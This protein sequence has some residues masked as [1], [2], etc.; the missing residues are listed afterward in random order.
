MRILVLDV[1]ATESGALSILQQF[2]REVIENSNQQDKW[3]FVVSTPELSESNNVK[4]L[5]YPWIKKSWFHRLYFDN[6]I[7][8]KIIK[9]LRI[10]YVFSL[11][12][13]IVKRVKVPQILYLHQPLPFVTKRYGLLENPKFWIY[14]NII[15]KEIIRSVKD[16]DS[17]IVQTEWV[18]T[19]LKKYLD[20][21]E[22]IIKNPP[23]VDF[24]NDFDGEAEFNGHEF[25]YPATPLEY[26]NHM[27]IVEACKLLEKEG[28]SDYS[29]YFT[30]NENDNPLAMN[31][32]KEI[33]AHNLKIYMVG[34]KSK[35][36]LAALYKNCTLLFPSYIE[37]F[38]LPMLESRMSSGLVLAADMPFSREVLLGYENAY[39]FEYQDASRLCELMSN[40]IN[41]KLH[42]K[43]IVYKREKQVALYDVIKELITK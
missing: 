22:K 13:V 19:S 36:Q 2:H 39:F 31:L 23:I 7:I 15:S 8:Q 32:K 41:Q 34:R 6:F 40:V 9:D 17:V 43:T 18:R 25:V 35:D 3:L 10:D 42:K 16:A 11:Q 14:Q 5:N 33:E 21:P 27:V 12:N 4:V 26:K 24:S 1:P 37:T 20:N 38:G 28:I 30:M 29:V